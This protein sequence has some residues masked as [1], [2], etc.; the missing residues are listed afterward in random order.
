MHSSMQ[1]ASIRATTARGGITACMEPIKPTRPHN[2]EWADAFARRLHQLEDGQADMHHLLDVG[3]ELY[4][5][6]GEEDPKLV[7]EEEF[8]RQ[9]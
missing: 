2:I 5:T 1:I 8:R 3:Y 4:S 6:R 9:G 7:A